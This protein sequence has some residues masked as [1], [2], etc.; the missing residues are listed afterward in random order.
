MKILQIIDSLEIG[1]AERM[2]VN[3]ANVFNDSKIENALVCTRSKGPLA[4][5]LPPIVSVFE[6][7]K[8]S[9]ID[10]FAFHELVK[11]VS[12]YQPSIIHVHSTSLFWGV[13]VRMF[14][15]NVKLIWHDHNGNRK[16]ESNLLIKF[17]L[18][19]V[20]GVIVV[21]QDLLEWVNSQL[22]R[23]KSQLIG[24]FP[25]LKFQPG[26]VKNGFVI[27]HLANLRNPKDH[28]NL[29]ESIR[30]LKAKTNVQF[31]VWCVGKDSK[32]AYSDIIKE[33]I[34]AYNLGETIKI[35]GA[36]ENTALCIQ[37]A[38]LGVLCSE[39]EGLPVSL[40]EYGLG[41]LPTVVTNVGQCAD[42]VGHGKFGTVVQA[43]SPMDLADALAWH[44]QNIADSIDLG[45]KFKQHVEENYGPQR[46]IQ[47]YQKMLSN[48]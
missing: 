10:F 1:G 24:N 37:R 7:N 28:L 21:N 25:L 48:L 23:K 46:F 12:I 6:I 5:F 3:M 18:K 15:P 13:L 36:V 39:S 34:S 14:H 47:D 43:S 29:V 9:S 38:S 45:V 8:K 42:V 40:L 35:F 32:D 44:I 19:F 22:P 20:S 33:K 4:N 17:F 2:A 26:V 11:L 30:I 27:L 16:K 41:A 31:E